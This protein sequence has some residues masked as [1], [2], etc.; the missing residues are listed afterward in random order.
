MKRKIYICILVCVS[1][2]I[3]SFCLNIYLGDSKKDELKEEVLISFINEVYKISD[4]EYEKLKEYEQ[5]FALAPTDSQEEMEDWLYEKYDQYLTKE[6]FKKALKSGVIIH[7]FR[8]YM[9]NDYQAAEITNIQTSK[10]KALEEEWYTY[11]VTLKV[12]EELIESRG[13]AFF[14]ENDL[15][16]ITK[17]AK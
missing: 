15:N 4:S 14:S 13:N 8:M 12:Q 3:A 1:I 16:K 5:K 6:A 10:N 9:N 7:G 11:T 2:V 17:I